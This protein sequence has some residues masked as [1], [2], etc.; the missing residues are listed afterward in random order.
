MTSERHRIYAEQIAALA[1]IKMPALRRALE[2][3]RREDFLPPGPWLIESLDGVYYPSD[4]ADPRHVLHG[5]G[6]AI[7]ANRMLNNAN[8]VKFAGQIQLAG[9]APGES[10]FHVGAGLGYFSALMAEMV[11][12]AGRVIAAEIDDGLR[13]RAAANLQPWPQAEVTGDALATPLPPIDFLYSSAGLGTLP[14]PW[15]EA[16]K[17]GGRMVLP[18]TGPH[19]HGI[20]FLFRKQAGGA[21]WPVRM[22]SFTRHY[23]CLGT[24][25]PADVT[26]LAGALA[27]PPSAVNSLRLDPH[28]RGA[29]CWLHG[30]GWCLSTRQ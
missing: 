13:A 29:D 30:D 14:L 10:V 16:L 7:D 17:P 26:A 27:R 22:L 28:E 18:V 5:V 9:L 11:G 12:P 8:P 20:V 3:V 24:R 15:L 4:D 25:E 21:P 2:K 19:D 6:V 1:G 23:P